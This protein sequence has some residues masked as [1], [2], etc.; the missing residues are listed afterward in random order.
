MRYSLALDEV[1]QHT[2]HQ[3]DKTIALK[4]IRFF[5]EAAK[6][7]FRGFNEPSPAQSLCVCVWARIGS[8]GQMEIFRK[9]GS[10]KVLSANYDRAK[11]S[12]C[13]FFYVGDKCAKLASERKIRNT[14]Q[15]MYE[16]RLRKE[17]DEGEE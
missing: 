5:A 8:S 4:R 17:T 3:T 1:S 6:K 15:R 13:S 9:G 12:V 14:I 10:K 7:E 16:E 11:K 2:Q